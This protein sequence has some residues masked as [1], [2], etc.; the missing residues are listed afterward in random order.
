MLVVA[1]FNLVFG[2]LVNQHRKKVIVAPIGML[3]T[4]RE[5][6][7]LYVVT[8]KRYGRMFSFAQSF[9][10]ASTP[11]TTVLMGPIVFLFVA[12]LC[13]SQPFLPSKQAIQSSI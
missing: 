13:L 4:I 12:L 7:I 10:T 5:F 8:L 11:I 1:I 2:T 9:E 6:W 3:F